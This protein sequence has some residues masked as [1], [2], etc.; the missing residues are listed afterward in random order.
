MAIHLL[1]ANKY[2]TLKDDEFNI[3]L[4]KLVEYLGHSNSIVSGV[5]FTEVR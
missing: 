5:A 1:C 3:V 2:R 4:V